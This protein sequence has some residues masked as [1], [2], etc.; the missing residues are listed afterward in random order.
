MKNSIF[1]P[2]I[3]SLIG[4][5]PN[6]VSSI[7]LTELYLNSAINF[8]SLISGLLT[9]SGIGILL[10]F[11]IMRRELKRLLHPRSVGTVHFEGKT[12][13]DATLSSVGSYFIL[14]AVVLVFSFLLLSFEPFGLET[15]LSAVVACFNNV[16]PGLGG[17]GPAACYADYSAF[18]KMVLSFAMLFG[19]L[20]I[21]PILFALSPS[22]WTR[23]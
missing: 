13:S 9:N 10:L 11:K 1:G 15:N 23:K 3:T 7:I 21:Y 8:A 6:C 17:V 16:G 18:S 14:Y 4:L 19:R 5:I 22:T 2:F 12:V 20:E